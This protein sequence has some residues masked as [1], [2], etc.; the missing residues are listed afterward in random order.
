MPPAYPSTGYLG[1]AERP[2]TTP[3]APSDPTIL[4]KM[5][6][7]GP[8]SYT[9]QGEGPVVVAVHGYPGGPRDWRWLAPA[10][11]ANIRFIRLAM[12]AFEQTPL[13]THPATSIDGRADFV[14]ACV[15]ALDLRDVVLLGHSMGGALAGMASLR[16]G[17]RVRG[18]GLLCSIGPTAHPSVRGNHMT[19][20]SQLLRRPILG[21]PLRAL[22]PRGFELMGFPRRWN[23]AQLMHTIDCAA[24]LD[25]PLWAQSIAALKVPTL[26]AWSDDDPLI[27][28]D[29]SVALADRAP[30]GPRL[31][32]SSG[33]HNIQKYQAVELA[34]AVR[35]FLNTL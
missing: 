15:E 24:A 6:S 17:D 16:L 27:P 26:V 19:R 14:A 28:K 1:L 29:I 21:W 22:L 12:P 7:S 4:L 3:S 13:A 35:A 5:T 25:F 30:S 23:N 8:F 2:M 10:L 31:S 32:F 34:A 11:G 33:G 18:L 20:A 9:D